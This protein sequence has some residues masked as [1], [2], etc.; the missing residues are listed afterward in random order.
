MAKEKACRTCRK[1]VAEEKTCPACSGTSFT[2]F[3][4]GYVVIMDPQ[5][6]E[7][8]QKMGITESGKYAL[9]LSR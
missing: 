8:A 5:N 9:R 3:W 2:T 7:I 4:R 1:V 6:S